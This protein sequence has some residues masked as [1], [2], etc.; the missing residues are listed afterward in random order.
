MNDHD[1]VLNRPILRD[2]QAV[3]Y[4]DYDEMLQTA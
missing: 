2:P 3:T 4:I 1:L